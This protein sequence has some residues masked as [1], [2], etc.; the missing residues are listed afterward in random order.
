MD[1]SRLYFNFPFVICAKNLSQEEARALTQ[2]LQSMFG[3]SYRFSELSFN[4]VLDDQIEAAKQPFNYGPFIG[5]RETESGE[6]MMFSSHRSQCQVN[7][8]NGQPRGVKVFAEDQIDALYLQ[9]KLPPKPGTTP[10]K[11]AATTTPA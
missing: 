6:R 3:A 8:R 11:A 5:V 10:V 2:K 1:T 4:D 9:G 7:G